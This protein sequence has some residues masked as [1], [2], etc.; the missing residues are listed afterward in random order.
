[1][2]KLSKALEALSLSS[3]TNDYT[4][5]QGIPRVYFPKWEGWSILDVG[6]FPSEDVVKSF[7]CKYFWKPLNGEF[8]VNQEIAN[9]LFTFSVLSG[10][11]KAINKIQRLLNIHQTGIID[12]VTLTAINYANHKT[13]F[14]ELYAEFI[15]LYIASGNMS[16]IK[17]LLPS[18]YYYLGVNR[19]L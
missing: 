14:L 17:R 15:E 6:E 9:L 4:S 12:E 2:A 18:Y 10:K 7:Y 16:Y 5:Y 8:I 11:K 3:F 19:Y 1:M 13:L